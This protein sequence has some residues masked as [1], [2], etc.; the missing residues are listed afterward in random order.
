M[1]WDWT[2]GE[3]YSIYVY[4]VAYYITHGVYINIQ[5]NEIPTSGENVSNSELFSICICISLH[6]HKTTF[7]NIVANEK[8]L[9]MLKL[10][11]CQN[12]FYYI[13]N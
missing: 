10:S 7:D 12:V 2:E 9:I 4:D 3:Y 1:T 11:L 6:S 8:F 13:L 5:R